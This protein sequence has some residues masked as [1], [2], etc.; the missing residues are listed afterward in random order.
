MV[1]VV[2]PGDLGSEFR[3][4]TITPGKITVSANTMLPSGIREFIVR[5]DSGELAAMTVFGIYP[6]ADVN[7]HALINET[8]KLLAILDNGA[9][10]Q[11]NLKE[12]VEMSGATTTGGAGSG[13]VSFPSNVRVPIDHSSFGTTW[14]IPAG[15][16]LVRVELHCSGG[17]SANA[18]SSLT[19]H[20]RV[21]STSFITAG[22]STVTVE[23]ENA[24]D[25]RIRIGG[26]LFQC[27]RILG[28]DGSTSAPSAPSFTES[29]SLIET[30]SVNDGG[31]K[32]YGTGGTYIRVT[33]Y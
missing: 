31:S 29:Y 6:V 33:V 11:F 27:L 13:T 9:I 8:T 22:T 17:S 23:A 2:T 5:T 12:L 32:E 14:T 15:A 10:R 19:R 30:D 1:N 7:V 20:Y 25:T 26:Q 4:G 3:L 16:E 18:S 24:H 21:A 28:G